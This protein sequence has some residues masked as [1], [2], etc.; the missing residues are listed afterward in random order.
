MPRAPIPDNACLAWLLDGAEPPYP[1]RA[2]VLEEAVLWLEGHRQR[3][4]RQFVSRAPSLD[5]FLEVMRVD[6]DLLTL[7]AWSDM[8]EA[9]HSVTAQRA[10]SAVFARS[11]EVTERFW[12]AKRRKDSLFRAQTRKLRRKVRRTGETRWDSQFEHV[13]TEPNSAEVQVLFRDMAKLTAKVVRQ[14]MRH[15]RK[16]EQEGGTLFRHWPAKA[17]PSLEEEALLAAR[18]REQRGFLVYPMEDPG[19]HLL[20][21]STDA[22]VRQHIWEE[23]QAQVCVREND[24]EKMRALR[25]RLAE[26]NEASDHATDQLYG[27]TLLT[28]PR[29]ERLMRRSLEQLLLPT[30]RAI[31]RGEAKH[32]LPEGQPADAFFAMIEGSACTRVPEVS[33][34]AFPWRSTATKILIE[35]MKL[36]GWNC[37]NAPK[38][39][40]RGVTR[41]LCFTFQRE[42]GQRAQVWYRP[43]NP[44]PSPNSQ[45]A[46]QACS[47]RETLRDEPF[48]RVCTIDQRLPEDRPNFTLMDVQYLCHEI[49]HVLHFLAMPGNE[50]Y[51]MGRLTNDFVELPAIFLESYYRQP[52]TLMRW[53]SSQAP[54][55]LRKRS[56]WT[57]R[58]KRY[59]KH[60]LQH[61]RAMFRAYLDFRLHRK[62]S[63][64]L[65]EEI[66]QA[67]EL[68]PMT[69][70]DALRD[71]LN[72]FD[73]GEDSAW[74]IC[75]LAGE[76]MAHR[77]MPLQAHGQVSSEALG[78]CFQQLLDVLARGVSG[79]K[80]KRLWRQWRNETMITS[81][82]AGFRS[83]TRHYVTLLSPRRSRSVH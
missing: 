83:M 21:R 78:Q 12:K 58:L 8:N 20:R 74:G 7:K 49:G 68:L 71:H 22:V 26:I 14:E 62:S 33:P 60:S 36:G 46:A 61:Q 76:A 34:L 56:Y 79:S 11:D 23:R 77:L 1:L 73:F 51:E 6:R 81:M 10:F 17:D 65:N 32:R 4:A 28:A 67:Y 2:A 52:E 69:L 16:I 66:A 40:G 50:I 13:F 37:L 31:R 48:T 30:T 59:A 19:T 55:S 54:K 29:A 41:M 75:H 18:R 15:G 27:C 80:L 47:V 53:M 64:P 42:D 9:Y 72:F 44:M 35:L 43:F 57:F 63:L 45:V 39:L 24:I 25:Q 3:A 82:D 70:T 5:L 38:A